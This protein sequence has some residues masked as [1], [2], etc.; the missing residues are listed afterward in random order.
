MQL[1]IIII[2]NKKNIETE[3]ERETTEPRLSN[4]QLP[5]DDDDAKYK[6]IYKFKNGNSEQELCTTGTIHNKR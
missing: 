6:K 3:H 2:Q 4:F 5:H 1:S